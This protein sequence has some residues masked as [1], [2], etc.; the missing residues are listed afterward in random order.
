MLTS[1]AHKLTEHTHAH[2]NKTHSTHPLFQVQNQSP[3][4]PCHQPPQAPLPKPHPSATT[5]G[6]TRGP[7]TARA[8]PPRHVAR[9]TAPKPHTRGAVRRALAHTPQTGR[10]AQRRAVQPV[11]PRP[12]RREHRRAP[13][14]A[15]RMQRPLVVRVQPLERRTDLALPRP[16]TPVPAPA[17][18]S[19][20]AACAHG[21]PSWAP[22]QR[23]THD[24]GANA[25]SQ[26][27]L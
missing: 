26:R 10:V 1:K 2:T 27:A 4:S 25:R 21:A 11:V 5:D 6:S 19:T 24:P 15:R 22:T 3:S 23:S 13:P 20:S 17:L 12:R 16:H 8:P 14:V 7:Q 18:R 9:R